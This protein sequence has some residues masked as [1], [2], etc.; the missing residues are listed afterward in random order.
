MNDS[1][2]Y[3]LRSGS[4]AARLGAVIPFPVSAMPGQDAPVGSGEPVASRRAGAPAADRRLRLT[5]RG[6]MVI[7]LGLA[8]IVVLTV[9]ALVLLQSQRAEAG[10]EMARTGLDYHVVVPGETLWQIAQAARP[11]EDPRETIAAIVRLNAL[12][13]ALI[14]PGQRIAVP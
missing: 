1:S 14:T 2:T 11:H 6:R 10:Q 3:Q 7:R 8:L 9:A 5:R 13:S 4:G 12:D